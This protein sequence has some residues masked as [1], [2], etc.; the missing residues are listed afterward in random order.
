MSV[1]ATDGSRFTLPS[2]DEIRNAFD[3]QR[4]KKING[5]FPQCL[6]STLYDVFRRLPVA[7]TIVST[8]NANEREEAKKHLQF[9]PSNSVWLFDKGYPSYDLI[10]HLIENFTGYFVFRC[11]AYSS[12]P[13]LKPFIA[14]SKKD[15]IIWITPSDKY[16]ARIPAKDRKKCK[17]IKLR[18]VKLI[19][20]KGKISVLLTN[21]YDKKQ[22]SEKEIIALYFR[23]WEI[24]GYYR[25]EKVVMEI[26]KFH[27]KTINGILQELY[28]AM[29]MSVITRILMVLSS[30]AFFAGEREMQFKNAIL[31]IA[32]EAAVLVP[33]NPRKAIEIFNEVII[34][35]SRVKY[36]RPK[37]PRSAQPRV[38]KKSVNKWRGNNKKYR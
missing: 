7:R 35:I 31:T 16:M 6:V 18:V 15:G 38:T 8:N 23:R 20:P 26:E 3:P 27:T 25:D 28:A 11:P 10:L 2:T 36:Y 5:H 17:N 21:L 4:G 19:N 13:A 22:F 34:E 32:S 37:I 14:S 9:I 30:D 24:E 29:I 12:F 33:E 1:F